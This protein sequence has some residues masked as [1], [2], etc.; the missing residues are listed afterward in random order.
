MRACY[1]DRAQ[2]HPSATVY[3]LRRSAES[4]PGKTESRAA[5]KTWLDGRSR[6]R[7]AFDVF[8]DHN[9][10][11]CPPCHREEERSGRKGRPYT[12]AER[13]DLG[14]AKP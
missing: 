1:P 13:I 10:S 9:R 5:G 2:S 11:N 4:G 6:V 7:Y 14:A 3:R 8:M 12:H